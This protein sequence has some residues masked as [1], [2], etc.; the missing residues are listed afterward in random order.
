MQWIIPDYID[1]GSFDLDWLP[2]LYE[3]PYIHQWPTVDG[4][5]LGPR[6]IDMDATEVKYHSSPVFK[7]KSL[8]IVFVSNGET[9][10]QRR[11]D[12]LCQ[13]AGRKVHWVRGVAGRENALRQA[14]ESSTTE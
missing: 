7:Y 11:Y 1:I 9:G 5:D 10:E 3:P 13:V 6:F 14:A 8:D 12:R 2:D 4:I